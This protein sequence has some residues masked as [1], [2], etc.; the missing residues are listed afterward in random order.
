MVDYK[1]MDNPTFHEE[2]FTWLAELREGLMS[3]ATWAAEKQRLIRKLVS[4]QAQ[5]IV[6]D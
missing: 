4:Y 5:Q 6:E 1:T 3:E 2:V